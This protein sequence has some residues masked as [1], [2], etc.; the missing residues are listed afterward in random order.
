MM[1]V[2]VLMSVTGCT[3]NTTDDSNVNSAT[4]GTEN[5]KIDEGDG[6]VDELLEDMENMTD[7]AEDKANDAMDN[8]DGVMDDTMNN[9]DKIDNT[10]GEDLEGGTT[11]VE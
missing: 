5:D 3:S 4:D 8:S 6:I 10:T 2:I 9:T 11:V 1:C 7:D